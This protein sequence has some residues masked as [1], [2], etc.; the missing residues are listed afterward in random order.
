VL[1]RISGQSVWE[2]SYWRHASP[3]IC[4]LADGLDVFKM[5]GSGGSDKIIGSIVVQAEGFWD[6]AAE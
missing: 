5:A 3:R 6:F 4:F 1:A 2:Y